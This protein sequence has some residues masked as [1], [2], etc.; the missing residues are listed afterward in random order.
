[1]KSPHRTILSMTP[2]L[3]L[4]DET[5]WGCVLE[6]G[7]YVEHERKPSREV[8]CDECAQGV[9]G[10]MP[11]LVRC[12]VCHLPS[13]QLR[14]G[15]PAGS[16]QACHGFG[17]CERIITEEEIANGAPPSK[18][19]GDHCVACWL[20][21]Q[22]GDLI[23][24]M[25]VKRGK[26]W[27]GEHRRGSPQGGQLVETR[28]RFYPKAELSQDAVVAAVEMYLDSS[29]FDRRSRVDLRTMAPGRRLKMTQQLVASF[30]RGAWEW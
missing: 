26:G 20:T 18:Q 30:V 6:C 14:P 12:T 1:M 16:C 8:K 24:T 25:V 9:R 13:G 22:D 19:T 15:T 3:G 7:H 27:V 28:T 23:T 2:R 4:N 5:I 17:W 29:R 11:Q 21:H 10:Y